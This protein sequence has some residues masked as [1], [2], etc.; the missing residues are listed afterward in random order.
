MLRRKHLAAS[1]H[2]RT[3]QGSCRSLRLSSCLHELPARVCQNKKYIYGTGGT[4]CCC[5]RGTA[6]KLALASWRVIISYLEYRSFEGR[7][8]KKIHYFWNKYVRFVFSNNFVQFITIFMRTKIGIVEGS[9]RIVGFFTR[10]F[11][12]K[13]FG[14]EI[15]ETNAV[16]SHKARLL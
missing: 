8:S 9:F 16:M 2:L 12:V 1:L 7:F 6:K 13:A 3:V 4:V 14:C 5:K 10:L 11:T 15:S